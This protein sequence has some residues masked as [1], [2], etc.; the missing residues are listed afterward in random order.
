MAHHFRRLA[1]SFSTLTLHLRKAQMT[2]KISKSLQHIAG[3]KT[4][5]EGKSHSRRWT[6]GRLQHMAKSKLQSR[7][8]KKP[9]GNKACRLLEEKTPFKLAPLPISFSLQLLPW[10]RGGKKRKVSQNGMN[11]RERREMKGET[12]QNWR[13]HIKVSWEGGASSGYKRG[14]S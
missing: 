7:S 10:K 1:H 3:D 14:I 2:K 13:E 12:W 9:K 8:S 6:A 11:Q 4:T 5:T